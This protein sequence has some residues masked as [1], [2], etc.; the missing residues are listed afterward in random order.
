MSRSV[1]VVEGVRAERHLIGRWRAR[2]RQ[3]KE[4][5]RTAAGMFPLLS[6]GSIPGLDC[7]CRRARRC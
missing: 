4:L 2:S 7:R 3:L 5:N 6:W 1:S